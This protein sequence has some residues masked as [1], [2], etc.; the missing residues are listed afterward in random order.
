MN[1]SEI[2]TISTRPL[3][4]WPRSLAYLY[5]EYHDCTTVSYLLLLH[6]PWLRHKTSDVEN[7]AVCEVHQSPA[8]EAQRTFAGGLHHL[9]HVE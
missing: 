7:A 4:L 1:D 2:F 8:S 6:E 5:G 3:F 9:L